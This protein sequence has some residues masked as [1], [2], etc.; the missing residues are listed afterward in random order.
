MSDV[1]SKVTPS[2]IAA[3]LGHGARHVGG[4]R[5]PDGKTGH[6][7]EATA[8]IQ[9]GII[10]GVAPGTEI[11]IPEENLALVDED[12]GKHLQEAA[13]VLQ[14]HNHLPK[15]PPKQHQRSQQN[16]NQ[17]QPRKGNH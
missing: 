9:S 17:M 7:H 6:L 14:H 8:T 1:E 5:I 10:E 12:I 4:R 16:M 2:E 15:A 11:K 13:K 3:N